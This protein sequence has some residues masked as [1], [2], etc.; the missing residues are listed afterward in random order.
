MFTWEPPAVCDRDQ[1]G[2]AAAPALRCAAY[3]TPAA[4]YRSQV[5]RW[6]ACS[7]RVMLG[8]RAGLPPL[9]NAPCPH[10]E[11]INTRGSDA[12]V[13]APICPQFGQTIL[14][15]MSVTM[16]GAGVVARPSRAC[17]QLQQLGDVHG[18]ARRSRITASEQRDTA[19]AWM[20]LFAVCA[21]VRN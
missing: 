4:S 7:S 21:D 6:A 14:V 11:Q 15:N 16:A 8:D 1:L 18:D 5:A 2:Q 20:H 17:Q 10:R 19:F 12:A 13:T 9:M 3:S